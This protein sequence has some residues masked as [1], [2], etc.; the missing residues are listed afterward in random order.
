MSDFLHLISFVVFK[1]IALPTYNAMLSLSVDKIILILC[2]YITLQLK[3]NSKPYVLEQ[4]QSAVCVSK[5]SFQR[6]AY[7]V[8]CTENLT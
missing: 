3:V 7:S 6:K 2:L 8:P 4:M 1:L 5:Y